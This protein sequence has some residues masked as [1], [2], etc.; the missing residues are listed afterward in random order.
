MAFHNDVDRGFLDTLFGLDTWTPP[1]QTWVG[2]GT[3]AGGKDGSTAAEPAGG[4]YARKQVSA[5]TRTGSTVK[6][7]AA[8]EF[9]E[10][11]GSQGTITHAYIF[12]AETG[13]NLVWSAALTASKAIVSGDTPRFPAADFAVTQG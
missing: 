13:G 9:D 10:A 11:T 2:Y 3:A 1:A 5:W 12:D 7:S 4:G 6:P 8:I